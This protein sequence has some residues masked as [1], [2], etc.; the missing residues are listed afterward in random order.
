MYSMRQGPWGRRE[1]IAHTADGK[2]W[3]GSSKGG[4][5]QERGATLASWGPQLEGA[6]PEKCK[7]ARKMC[8]ES[9]RGL[10]GLLSRA[11][12]GVL[13]KL[14]RQDLRSCGLSTS[15]GKRQ[16][17]TQPHRWNLIRAAVCHEHK[18]H[19]PSCTLST[20]VLGQGRLPAVQPV[21]P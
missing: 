7:Q 15:D 13:D 20:D 3:Q 18:Q 16:P 2:N 8:T 4:K 5:A 17:L 11:H 1:H 10:L 21:S 19:W 12:S 9:L 6:L 14:P